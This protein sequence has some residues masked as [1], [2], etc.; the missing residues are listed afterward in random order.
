MQS[1]EWA[2]LSVVTAQIDHLETQRFAVRLRD[3]VW[4]QQAYAAKLHAAIVARDHLVARI[5][6]QLGEE[7]R[8]RA[9]TAH[10]RHR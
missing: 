1:L 7:I 5:N 10:A 2:E 9:L 3:D 8:E 4:Q 6:E